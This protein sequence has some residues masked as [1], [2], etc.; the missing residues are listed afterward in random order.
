M[1]II[2]SGVS[3]SHIYCSNG[4][5]WVIGSEMPDYK[6]AKKTKCPKQQ[7]KHHNNRSKDT[8]VF[9]FE[10]DANKLSNHNFQ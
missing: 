3:I 1:L 5:S 10:I 2:S 9:D 7:K 4:E 6:F 8:Y